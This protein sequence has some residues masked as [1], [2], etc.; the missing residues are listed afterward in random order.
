[1]PSPTTP[2]NSSYSRTLAYVAALAAAAGAYAALV[3]W[4]EYNLIHN[5]DDHPADLH[6]ALS[7]VLGLLLVFRTNA[8]YDRWWEARTLWGAL[9]NASRNLAA[10]VVGLTRVPPDEASR[11]GELVVAFPPALRDHLRREP[12]KGLPPEL[13]AAAD[14]VGHTPGMIVRRVYNM[15]GVWKANAWI[16]GDELRVLDREAAKLLDICGGCERIL[17]TRIARSYRRFA[18]SASCCSCS[19][20]RGGS[21]TPSGGGPRR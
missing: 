6:S 10:K 7:L 1:M 5:P 3:V 18:R 19:R 12:V 21:S 2:L 17:S 15:L 16:D 11:L 20:C 8:A 4:I 13:A 9:V 14:A